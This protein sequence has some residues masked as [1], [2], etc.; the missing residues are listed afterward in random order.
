MKKFAAIMLALVFVLAVS[1]CELTEPGILP[2]STAPAQTQQ[3]TPPLDTVPTESESTRIL[4]QC[5][6]NMRT[7]TGAGFHAAFEVS[8]DGETVSYDIEG[9]FAFSPFAC[10]L[11]MSLPSRLS[12]EDTLDLFLFHA[13][14]GAVLYYC[15]PDS[16]E[17][18]IR[19]PPEIYNRTVITQLHVQSSLDELLSDLFAE[20][21]TWEL[22]ETGTIYI[23]R[24]AVVFDQVPAILAAQR[25]LRYNQLNERDGSTLQDEPPQVFLCLEIDREQLLL[26]HVSMD[27]SEYLSAY[28]NNNS[29][30]VVT[31]ELSVELSDY[32]AIESVG[33][34]LLWMDRPILGLSLGDGPAAD[35]RLE[36]VGTLT[37]RV[38]EAV[39][40]IDLSAVCMN[41]LIP[42][43]WRMYYA[44]IGRGEPFQA[45]L[46]PYTTG[47]GELSPAN[48]SAILLRAEHDAADMPSLEEAMAAPVDSFFLSAALDLE[49][50]S[51]NEEVS[52]EALN[53]IRSGMG[54]AEA[55]RILGEPTGRYDEGFFINC[56]WS[57]GKNLL[58]LYFLPENGLFAISRTAAAEGALIPVLSVAPFSPTT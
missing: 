51:L 58:S 22:D 1:S 54:E 9:E 18:E 57:D 43:G 50:G 21:R 4:S 23:L 44:G 12:T 27:L 37:V 13:D 55:I 15:M 42:I 31:A 17:L 19:K 14:A 45:I 46:E 56:V 41:D 6:E 2:E 49:A 11:Q 32:D 40:E 39:G 24:T 33:R 47:I 25:G 52:F 36:Q 53:G 20:D 30:T 48:S 16:S 5:H 3:D 38:G 8:A 28:L 29:S 7:M 35:E 10:H 26:R 34:P